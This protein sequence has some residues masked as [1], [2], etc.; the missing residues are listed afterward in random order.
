MQTTHFL[1]K[2]LIATG[3]SFPG[4]LLTLYPNK[5]VSGNSIWT[6]PEKS[7]IY[8][9]IEKWFFKPYK[10]PQAL[11]VLIAQIQGCVIIEPKI[12]KRYFNISEDKL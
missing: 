2:D 9:V 6:C 1:N 12:V 11:N 3:T 5:Y 4:I 10:P 8:S 7:T